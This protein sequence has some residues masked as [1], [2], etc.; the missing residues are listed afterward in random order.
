[1]V[2]DEREDSAFSVIRLWGGSG[3]EAKNRGGDDRTKGL[4]WASHNA[5]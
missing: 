5:S 4:E 2:I 3:N 1:V